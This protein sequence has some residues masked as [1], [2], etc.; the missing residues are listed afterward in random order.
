MTVPDGLDRIELRGLEV[1]GHHGVLPEERRDGQPFVLDVT[2]GLD[3]QPAAETDDLALTV[4]YGTL[5]QQV[6]DAVATDPVDLIETVALRV[7]DLCLKLEQVRWVSV[8]VHK[9]E[10]PIQVT[11]EDVAVTIERSRT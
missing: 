2:L 9:P 5:A 4:D 1:F 6:H 8:T 7:V 3:L 11:F 10:A